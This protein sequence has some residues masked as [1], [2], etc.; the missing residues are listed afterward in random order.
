MAVDWP[1]H[2]VER[3]AAN[4]WVLFVGSGVSASCVNG[5]DESPPTWPG[6]LRSLS[7]LITDDDQKAV[8]LRLIET[9][10]LL[11]AADHIRYSL[12][13]QGEL[14]GYHRALKRAVEGPQGDPFEPSVIYEMLLSLDPRIVFTTN[15]DKLFETASKGGYATHRFDSTT[16]GADIRR[17]DAVLVKL[18]GSTDSITEVVLTRTD[19]ARLME[20]K[21]EEV[22]A[23]LE[24]LSRTST[25][26]FLG[27]SL[28]DPDIQLAMQSV[29]RGELDPEAHYM[30]SEDPETPSRVPVFRDSFGVSVLTYP[31]GDHQ[32]V[33][34]ALEELVD[35]VLVA[36]E[37]LLGPS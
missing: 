18:H 3:I 7:E 15:Y 20:K 17:G 30:L 33:V 22:L 14:N 35:L 24:A 4:Q 36:R 25:I 26:L 29:G 5:A 9:N 21:G 1:S 19:Y 10:Q 2:L 27:Y 6:L 12:D 32:Q 34:D 13:G 23:T 31:A 16:L 37:G 28:D 8:G 11:S